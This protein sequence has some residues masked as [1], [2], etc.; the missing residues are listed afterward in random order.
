MRNKKTGLFAPSP[1][2]SYSVPEKKSIIQR[3]KVTREGWKKNE[4]RT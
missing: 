3:N 4:E 1:K 2:G